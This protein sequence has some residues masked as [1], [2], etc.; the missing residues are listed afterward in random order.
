MLTWHQLCYCQECKTPNSCPLGQDPKTF[1]SVGCCTQIHLANCSNTLHVTHALSFQTVLPGLAHPFQTELAN[2]K[3]MNSPTWTREQFC[4]H[5]T[6]LLGET[7]GLQQHYILTACV[8]LYRSAF[9]ACP[10]DK[11]MC[12]GDANSLQQQSTR[13]RDNAQACL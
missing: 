5:K 6:Q 1:S 10:H 3:H 9:D 2:V 7:Q 12:M 11:L 8:G 13:C 4:K